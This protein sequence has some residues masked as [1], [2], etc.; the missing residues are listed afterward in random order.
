[1]DEERTATGTAEPPSPPTAEPA[2]KRHEDGDDH[3][4]ELELNTP[5][6]IV[7]L[8][9]E[10]RAKKERKD[11]ERREKQQRLI[12]ER[13]ARAAVKKAERPGKRGGP[14][15]LLII[16]L[17]LAIVAGAIALAI[18]LFARPGEEDQDA[19]PNEMLKEPAVEPPAPAGFVDKLRARLREA[20]RQG[21]RASREAQREQQQ[22]F[23]EI[24][25]R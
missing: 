7:E 6:G 9:F 4:Y 8:E 15:S 10:P 19:I 24:S 5:F 18:W 20:V 17:V 23:R 2:E 16:L 22:R 12:A 11:R 14:N 25:N 3:E 13:E 1:M 21:R